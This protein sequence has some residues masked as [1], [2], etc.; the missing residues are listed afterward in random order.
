MGNRYVLEFC[1]KCRKDNLHR[2][3]KRYGKAS[4][5]N[6]K[7]SKGLRRIVIWCLKCQKRRIDNQRRQK[8][9]NM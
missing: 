6:G 9:K 2:V 4:K 7:G 5:G 8:R 1:P 3:F